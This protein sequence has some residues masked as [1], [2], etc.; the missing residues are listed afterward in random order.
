MNLTDFIGI[1]IVGAA[2]SLAIE[3]VKEKF[4]TASFGTKIITLGLSLVVGAAYWFLRETP[5]WQ[6]IVGVLAAASTVYAFVLK[7]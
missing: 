7:K 2:L 6:T 4:G 3:I 1:A 5:F